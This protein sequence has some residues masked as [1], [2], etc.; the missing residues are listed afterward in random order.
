MG[1]NSV[2]S[3]PIFFVLLRETIEAGLVVSCCLSLVDQL[4]PVTSADD[5]GSQKKLRKR[6]RWMVSSLSLSF[7][8]PRK[9]LTLVL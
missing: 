5:Q 6:M 4:S 3:V 9:L 1:G 8:S 7:S 2:F